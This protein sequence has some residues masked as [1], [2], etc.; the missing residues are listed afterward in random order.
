MCGFPRS[1]L[2]TR[3]L[4]ARQLNPTTKYFAKPS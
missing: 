2:F 4:I 1:E 3:G